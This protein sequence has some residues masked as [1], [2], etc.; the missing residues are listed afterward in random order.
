MV[1]CTSQPGSG[2]LPGHT[3][4]SAGLALSPQ[5][6]AL[7]ARLRALSTPIIG[8]IHDGALVLD[9]RCLPDDAALIAALSA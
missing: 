2:A 9:L 3:L 5:P 1:P 8:R 7:A 4:A 6:E